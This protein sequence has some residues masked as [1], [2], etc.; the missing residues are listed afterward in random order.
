M[1]RA[2][3]S[4]RRIASHPGLTSKVALDE[5]VAIT[6]ISNTVRESRS[7]LTNRTRSVL[8]ILTQSRGTRNLRGKPGIFREPLSGI[9]PLVKVPRNLDTCLGGA[10]EGE[11]AA[12]CRNHTI[13]LGMSNG[14]SAS[15]L[16]RG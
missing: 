6:F 5:K 1:A 11:E 14:R 16:K 3:V 7:P 13:S 8:S 2:V 15:R 12:S 4:H 10:L 9:P